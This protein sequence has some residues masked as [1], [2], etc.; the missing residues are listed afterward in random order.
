MEQM[1]AL[2]Q[3][4]RRRQ[5]KSKSK[6]K[7]SAN[8]NANGNLSTASSSSKQVSSSSELR[9]RRALGVDDKTPVLR[10]C[11]RIQNVTLRAVDPEV[12]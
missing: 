9:V 10:L 8:S 4:P 7:S 5:S 6:S 1:E 3:S 11:D 12:N 2:F